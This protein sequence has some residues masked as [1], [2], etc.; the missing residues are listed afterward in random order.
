MPSTTRAIAA[1]SC[2]RTSGLK[3][4]RVPRSVTSD[5]I[6]LAATPPSIMQIDT[7]ADSSGSMVR[8]TT[9]CSATS[10]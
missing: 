5:G 4:L 8:D 2:S 9:D 10:K 7:T 6:W 3:A 1:S